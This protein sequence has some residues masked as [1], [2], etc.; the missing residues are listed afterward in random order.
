[1]QA[2]Y[3]LPEQY[4]VSRLHQVL[5]NLISRFVKKI[6]AQCIGVGEVV[7]DDAVINLRVVDR[8][9]EWDIVAVHSETLLYGNEAKSEVT[10]NDEL[11]VDLNRGTTDFICGK[12]EV[13]GPVVPI[14]MRHRIFVELCGVWGQFGCSALSWYCY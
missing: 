2:A 9:G 13:D 10:S 12:S 4:I 6:G 3:H 1:M 5:Q 14:K 7:P 8:V 11:S